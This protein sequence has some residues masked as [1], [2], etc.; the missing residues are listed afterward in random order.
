MKSRLMPNSKQRDVVRKYVREELRKQQNETTRRMFKMLCLVL[1]EEYGFGKERL[2][3]VFGR[4]EELCDVKDNDPV[5]WS[6]V[7]KRMKQ[8]GMEFVEENYDEL[9]E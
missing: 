4:V 2:A 6:H 1:N 3:R 9:D 5:F 8:I 7:D